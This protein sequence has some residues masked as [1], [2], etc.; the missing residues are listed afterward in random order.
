MKRVPIKRTT[1]L[2][3]KGTIKRATKA[4]PG[5]RPQGFTETTKAEVRRRSGN[6]CEIHGCP[7]RATQFHHRKLRRH[8]DH[9]AVNCLHICTDHHV[10]IHDNVEV[11]Y[12]MGWLVPSYKDPADVPL[13]AA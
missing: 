6:R 4:K 9:R 11:S 5:K 13:R 1:P 3:P 10:E 8:G 12:V 7:H 2:R